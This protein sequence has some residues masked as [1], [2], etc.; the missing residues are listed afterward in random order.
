MSKVAVPACWRL[1]EE[2]LTPLT[3]GMSASRSMTR[4]TP[5]TPAPTPLIDKP[6]PEITG[7]VGVAVDTDA[8]DTGAVSERLVRYAFVGITRA[9]S[10]NARSQFM[11]EA[12]IDSAAVTR[13]W[14]AAWAVLIAS[15][16]AWIAA[17]RA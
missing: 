3:H 8:V 2:R 15:T 11:R 5:F 4:A 7:A 13:A 1:A 10:F 6:V 17:T 9:K 12:V 14:V 16:C